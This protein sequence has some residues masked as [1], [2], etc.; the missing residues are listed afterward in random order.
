M[1]EYGD[2]NKIDRE[3]ITY[4]I[5]LNNSHVMSINPEKEHSKGASIDHTQAVRFS[6]D[7]VESRILVEAGEVGAIGGE[8]Y[9]GR[10]CKAA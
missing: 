5:D 3:T 1:H 10:F 8:V 6:R 4:T 7:K 2:R 9:Q